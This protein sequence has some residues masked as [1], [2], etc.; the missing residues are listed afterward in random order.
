MKKKIFRML[1]RA[2]KILLPKLWNKDLNRLSKFQK[3][4]VAWKYYVTRN[5]L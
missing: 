4:M 1:A 3:L 5:S 2:N